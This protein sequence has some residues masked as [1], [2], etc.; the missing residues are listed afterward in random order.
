[1]QT[2]SISRPTFERTSPAAP[3]AERFEIVVLTLLEEILWKIENLERDIDAI[4]RSLK[5]C[6]DGVKVRRR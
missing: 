4:D 3:R 1:M 6:G 2:T 5:P